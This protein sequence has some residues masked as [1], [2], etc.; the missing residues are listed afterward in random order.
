MKDSFLVV[1]DRTGAGSHKLRKDR[2]DRT[3]DRGAT[4]EV[5]LQGDGQTVGIRAVELTKPLGEDRG[6]RQSEAIDALLDVS[7]H[8][9]IIAAIGNR[10]STG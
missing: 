5:T 9:Q 8:E 7:D 3:E 4:A 6:I 10:F 1:Y 2:V